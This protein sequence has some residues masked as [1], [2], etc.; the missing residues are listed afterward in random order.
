LILLVA[1]AI[2]WPWQHRCLRILNATANKL[3][4]EF[5]NVGPAS[6][7]AES[8]WHFETIL[9]HELFDL[10]TDFFQKTNVYKA[11]SAEMKAE[12]AAW[13]LAA[14]KCDGAA[15]CHAARV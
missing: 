4:C 15:E 13:M 8:Y 6:E 14:Y 1:D 5:T 10:S 3:Y 7:A 12:L 9:F 11:A 2:R